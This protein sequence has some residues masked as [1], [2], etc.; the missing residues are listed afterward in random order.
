MKISEIDYSK[1]GREYFMDGTRVY[2]LKPPIDAKE[3]IKEIN[4]IINKK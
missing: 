2:N 1:D 3:W 4:K